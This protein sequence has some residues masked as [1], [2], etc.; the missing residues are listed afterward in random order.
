MFPAIKAFWNLS[1]HR[2]FLGA[3]HIGCFI[4][5]DTKIPSFGRK[6]GV[7]HRTTLYTNGMGR[8]SPSFIL[9]SESLPSIFPPK[10]KGSPA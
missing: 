3:R 5:V 9:K 4:L 2:S 8:V 6:G 1:A 10:A 7:W